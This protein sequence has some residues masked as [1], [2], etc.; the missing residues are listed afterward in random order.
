MP[1]ITLIDIT[2]PDT[3]FPPENTLPV[4]NLPDRQNRDVWLPRL[5]RA[6]RPFAIASLEAISQEEVTRL[7]E[8]CRRRKLPVAILNAYRLI[9]VFARLREVAVSGCLGVIDT[10]KIHVPSAVSDVLCADLALW[11]LPNTSPDALSRADDNRIAVAMSGSNGKAEASLN[12][13]SYNASLVIRIGE[14]ARIITVPSATSAYSA[15][16]DILSNTFLFAHRWP[17][18]MH[19][20]EAASAITLAE[21]FATNGKK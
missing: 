8:T 11:L 10:V 14:T 12:M 20:D 13:D 6:K 9:P 19:A 2:R 21:A 16:R 7:A 4:I 18:L 17:L 15:E 1:S 3:D 5:I